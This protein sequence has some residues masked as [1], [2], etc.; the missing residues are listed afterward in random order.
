[1]SVTREP[2]ISIVLATHNR[3]DVAVD[4]LERVRRCEIDTVDYELIVVDNASTDGTTQAVAD[5]ADRVVPLSRNLGSCAKGF[6]VD[7]ARGRLIVFLD[8]DSS[9]R[10]GSLTR[11]IEH[12]DA[13]PKLGAA[14]FRVHL[15]DGSEEC[16]ALPGVFVGCGVGFQAG[17]LR[18]VGG[19]D[20]T[21]FMQAEEYDLA[22]RLV[23]AGWHVRTFH[24]L[25]VDHLKTPH[26]RRPER[27][28]FFDTRNNLRV[29][30]RY[31]PR[32]GAQLYREDALQRYAW[33]AH[34]DGHDRAFNRGRSAGTWRGRLE[35][36]QYRKRRLS[37]E[38]F[39]QFYRWSE[40][41]RRMQGLAQDGLRRVALIGFGKNLLAFH[42]AALLARLDVPSIG[43]DRFAA[44]ER[45]Y[46]NTPVA[47]VERALATA[48]DAVVIS[49]MAPVFADQ[50][51]A[52]ARSLTHAPVFN[53]FGGS[54]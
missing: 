15:P 7:V 4:T 42:R 17:V 47:T 6:G 11:M 39:E 37:P 29:I 45:R 14:G 2:Q 22:F 40:L 36:V 35:R 38:A 32:L 43:D 25:H 33:L 51:F 28:T 3:R 26:A 48:H 27:T 41:E 30:A 21:F 53:W 12:F 50:A 54:S 34:R 23:D 49:N 31:L 13:D 20:R 46:R 24:D 18:A 44:S 9:P 16:G 1:M 10:L 52:R 8:D 5:L 19:L